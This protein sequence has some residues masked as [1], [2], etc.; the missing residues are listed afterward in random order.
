M[1]SQ[2]GGRGEPHVWQ[3]LQ[4]QTVHTGCGH[5][6]RDASTRCPGEGNR[7]GGELTFY[8]TFPYIAV[9]RACSSLR[10]RTAVH[11]GIAYSVVQWHE[12]SVICSRRYINMVIWIIDLKKS[13]DSVNKT[14]SFLF[15]DFKLCFASCII[16][17]IHILI[18]ERN[19]G[20]TV[21]GD[22]T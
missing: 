4:R 20:Y 5:S 1:C 6:D 16:K 10:R 7:G 9:S 22:C 15:K 19:V 12:M 11:C 13:T 2:V 3:M 8:Y 17:Y 21:N 18:W 14:D